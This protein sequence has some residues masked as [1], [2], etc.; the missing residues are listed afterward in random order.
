MKDMTLKALF[1]I[2]GAVLAVSAICVVSIPVVYCFS[3]GFTRWPW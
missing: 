2:G 1:V 3:E